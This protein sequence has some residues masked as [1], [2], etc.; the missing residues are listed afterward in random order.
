MGAG[1][2]RL[3]ELLNPDYIDLDREIERISDK[4]ISE[5]FSNS[6]EKIFR[7]I[8]H[9]TFKNLLVQSE[10]LATGGG[11][12]ENEKNIELLKGQNQVIYLKAD[13]E[14]LWRRIKADKENIRP[15]AQDKE[16]ARALLRSRTRKYEAVAD[17]VIDVSEKNPVEIADEIRKWLRK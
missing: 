9:Q 13:F 17:F 6:G 5:I 10:L 11:I 14:S 16:K 4:K 2:T 7:E 3:A 8:E 15:L 12:V 1:K